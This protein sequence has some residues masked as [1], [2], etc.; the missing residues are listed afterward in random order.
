MGP[1]SGI[2]E[3][4]ARSVAVKVIETLPAPLIGSADVNVL[5]SLAM[6]AE[7]RMFGDGL[8]RQMGRDLSSAAVRLGLWTE[9]HVPCGVLPLGH[10][11]SSVLSVPEG[12]YVATVTVGLMMFCHLMAKCMAGF[13]PIQDNPDALTFSCDWEQVSP[14]L[15]LPNEAH[16]RFVD[17][18]TAANRG[19]VFET[20]PFSQ[21]DESMWVAAVLRHT[22]SSSPSAPYWPW[23]TPTSPKQRNSIQTAVKS[24]VPT[25]R[26]CVWSWS[27]PMR[28]DKRPWQCP[29]SCFILPPYNS[30]NPWPTGKNRRRQPPSA[31]PASRRQPVPRRTSPRTP[32]T[33]PDASSVPPGAVATS[34]PN[35]SEEHLKSV[36]GQV[37]RCEESALGAPGCLLAGRGSACQR[38]ALSSGLG[39][40]DDDH[41]ASRWER[42]TLASRHCR[43]RI[44]PGV[45]NHLGRV[46]NGGGKIRTPQWSC[47]GLH[48]DASPCSSDSYSH[49]NRRSCGC[50]RRRRR[51]V[52]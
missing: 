42:G 29:P 22:P 25:T 14:Q 46:G 2:N 23:P 32:P 48:R 44:P 7:R 1:Q 50:N 45:G 34:R 3:A 17:L 37:Q 41:Q 51:S 39:A 43:C 8:V 52:G 47:R 6:G 28:R 10:I 16:D 4:T 36:A 24:P 12:G 26:P 27:S 38:D 15:D 19:D 35:S 49:C 13:L 9:S 21:S 40:L 33:R 20:P 5:S 30:S 11:A 31:W 18:L